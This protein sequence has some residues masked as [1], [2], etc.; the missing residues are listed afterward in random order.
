MLTSDGILYERTADL[1]SLNILELGVVDYGN[2]YQLQRRL[3]Q[4][5]FLTRAE[6]KLVPN[7]YVYIVTDWEDYACSILEAIER[8]S[9]LNNMFN[10][11]APPVQWRPVT[12]FEKK[13]LSKHHDIFEIRIE[14]TAGA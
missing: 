5:P 4:E 12:P 8:T 6:A 14:K 11:F 1:C 13:G 3:V 10:G 7:G 2:A 9:G